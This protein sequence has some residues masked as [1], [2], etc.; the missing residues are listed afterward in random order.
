MLGLLACFLA[1]AQPVDAVQLPINNRRKYV[2]E[3]FLNVTLTT[4]AYDSCAVAAVSIEQ[5]SGYVMHQGFCDQ[6]G[7][8]KGTLSSLLPAPYLH[9]TDPNSFAGLMSYNVTYISHDQARLLLD[10]SFVRSSLRNRTM[11][12]PTPSKSAT[13][14]TTPGQPLGGV[15]DCQDGFNSQEFLHL[16]RNKILV[17]MGDSIT[18]QLFEAL[19][20]ELM[21][22][23][24]P[25]IRNVGPFLVNGSYNGNGTHAGNEGT[26]FDVL[27]IRNETTKQVIR[28]IRYVDQLGQFVHRGKFRHYPG[29][30]ASIF[31]CENPRLILEFKDFLSDWNFCGRQSIAFLSTGPQPGYLMVGVG[32]WFKPDPVSPETPNYE[33]RMKASAVKMAEDAKAFRKFIATLL[34]PTVPV[35]WRLQPH[36][37][38][39]DELVAA[40]AGNAT[41]LA[42]IP[43]HTDNFRWNG[44]PED[45]DALWPTYFNTVV[46]AVAAAH[47]DLVLD[48]YTLSRNY[49]RYFYR[50]NRHRA[51][52][53]HHRNKK[54]A[55]DPKAAK[56][57]KDSKDSNEAKESYDPFHPST[58]AP[59]DIRPHCDSLHYHAG[60][61]FRSTLV[62]L[63]DALQYYDRCSGSGSGSGSTMS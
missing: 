50:I 7:I 45:Q 47:S 5:G 54:D 20:I 16:L 62:V 3:N 28:T 19:E 30:N 53:S 40:A 49:L 61:F 9:R 8:N 36:V 4:N 48:Y 31:W 2:A 1:H 41:R 55:K 21:P 25:I 29:W 46:R 37:A 43:D 26:G 11:T 59:P 10:Y 57:S 6:S 17:V 52:R 58:T 14:S 38:N 42:A 56:D 60:G 27:L 34:A 13:T 18:R 15:V 44:I 24:T 33:T 32:A 35:M 63:H 23:Q 12:T 22:F 39:R 51:H